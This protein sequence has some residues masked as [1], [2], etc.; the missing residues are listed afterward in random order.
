MYETAAGMTPHHRLTPANL[1]QAAALLRAIAT[2]MQSVAEAAGVVF[3][4][5]EA[6]RIANQH[7][8]VI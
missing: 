3:P 5:N 1:V 6:A 2:E 4:P 7:R 8:R